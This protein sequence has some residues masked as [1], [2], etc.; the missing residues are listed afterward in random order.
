MLEKEL[1]MENNVFLV[2]QELSG[3]GSVLVLYLLAGIYIFLKEKLN[4][5]RIIFL[6]LPL[7]WL[8]F[9]FLPFTY[10]I[11]E[12]VID[13]EL[14]YRFFWLLPVVATIA[15]ASVLCVQQ[16]KEK[17]KKLVYV[18]SIVS[19]LVCGD[20]VYNNWR[21]SL[22]EN[23]YH[24]PEVVVQICDSMHIE[25]REV[26]AV[27]PVELMQYVRQYDPTIITPYGRDTLV[28]AWNIR[29]PLYDEM[30]R[31]L[32]LGEALTT[33]ASQARCVYIVLEESQ[34]ISGNIESNGYRY[35]ETIE[36][37]QLYYNEDFLNP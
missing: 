1:L 6:Y 30:E 24:V 11:I 33:E 18:L 12:T 31:E 25:G 10:S 20:F 7:L 9:L 27:F 14:Y 35:L 26:L 15:Y 19:I 13:A 8:A 23:K 5:L 37:Y 34:E 29:H 17:H 32:I 3:T 16:A 36:G 28:E 22:A 2:W 4:Y 21:Y